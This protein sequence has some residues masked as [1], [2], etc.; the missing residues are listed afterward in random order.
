MDWGCLRTGAEENI[1]TEEGCSD[2]RLEKN[3]Y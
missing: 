3:A 2:R 1:Q